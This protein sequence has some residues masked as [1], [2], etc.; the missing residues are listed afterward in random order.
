MG[1]PFPHYDADILPVSGESDSLPKKASVTEPPA[2]A[3]ATHG[4]ALLGWVAGGAA[5][6]VAAAR[7]LRGPVRIVALGAVHPPISDPPATAGGSVD[8][9]GF[10]PSYN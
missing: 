1:S 7:F 2:R 10:Y 9:Q 3:P 5:A 6:C 8:F 4:L